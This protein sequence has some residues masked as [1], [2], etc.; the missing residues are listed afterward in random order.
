MWSN[1]F[2][3]A[4]VTP[5]ASLSKLK[6]IVSGLSCCLAGDAA[7]QTFKLLV[8]LPPALF[9]YLS[10]IIADQNISFHGPIGRVIGQISI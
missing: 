8:I 4:L 1:G 2:S 3:F 9:Y 6:G 10:I 5:I 7:K